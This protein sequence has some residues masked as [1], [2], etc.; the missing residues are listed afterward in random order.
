MNLIPFAL[1]LNTNLLVDVDDVQSGKKCGCICPSCNIPF[2][3]RKGDVNEWHFAHDSQFIE[4][5]PRA[6]L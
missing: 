1:S 3:A 4:K 2:I 6:L 5:I